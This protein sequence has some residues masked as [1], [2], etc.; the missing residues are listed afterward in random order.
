M[1][2]GPY[3]GVAYQRLVNSFAVLTSFRLSAYLTIL[4]DIAFPLSMYLSAKVIFQHVGRIGSWGETEFL[5]F[6]VWMQTLSALHSG[7]AAPN[8]WNF[9]T[10]LRMGSLDYRLVRPLGVLFDCFTAIL[11]PVPILFMPVYVL[12]LLCTGASL[13]IPLT[14]WLLSPLYFSVSFL[15]L[16]LVELL[17]SMS[18]FWT[19][20]GE[21]I[22]FVR[23]QAQQLQRWPDF[24][25]P[26]WI[27]ITL[28][29]V[30]P[31]LAVGSVPVRMML[32][33][34]QWWEGPLLLL[35]TALLWF[36]VARV[37]RIGIRRYESASS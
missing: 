1:G 27:R 16:L 17:I 5:F 26:E 2:V 21:G 7:I 9:A 6:I 22:N 11:R 25:Y 30:I 8:F 4:T 13:N 37:W 34:A 29:R 14:Q 18:M 20:S 19:T 36:V 28:G 23:I 10:E 12:I 35:T 15:A 32:G 31:M 3:I 33:T 24:M